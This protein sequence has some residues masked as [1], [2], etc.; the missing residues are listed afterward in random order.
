MTIQ[1]GL[2]Y[3]HANR[4]TGWSVRHGYLSRATTK[5]GIQSSARL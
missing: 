5:S 3:Q 1:A 4:S 2:G